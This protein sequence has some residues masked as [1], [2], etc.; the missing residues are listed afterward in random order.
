[1]KPGASMAFDDRDVT[2]QIHY[3]GAITMETGGAVS[4]ALEIGG[5]VLLG[6]GLAGLV[7]YISVQWVAN[8]SFAV[9]DDLGL[10]TIAFL[11]M[12]IWSKV[13]RSSHTDV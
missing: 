3:E 6:A 10:A 7:L 12:S 11:A 8:V 5:V 2:Q 13:G 4:S 9:A 1:M